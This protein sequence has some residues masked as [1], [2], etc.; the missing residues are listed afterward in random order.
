MGVP[1]VTM[2][3]GGMAELV[4]DGKTGVL[5]SAPTPESVAEAI[6]Q[7]LSNEECYK[8][9]KANCETIGKN[10][11]GVAEYCDI[12]TKQYSNLIDKR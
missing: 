1:V 4:E 3:Y 5:A 2:N 7:C 6:N 12:L 8:T 10:I 9:I 11:M